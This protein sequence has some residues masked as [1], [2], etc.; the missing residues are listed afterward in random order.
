MAPG[1]ATRPDSAPL[2][3]IGRQ[4]ASLAVVIPAFRVTQQ[5]RGVIES[6]PSIVDLVYVVDDGCPDGSGRLVEAECTD[7]RVRVLFNA[8]NLGVGGA[9]LRGYREAI[10]D[11]AGIIVK[12]D[13]DG[14]MDPAMIERLVRPIQAGEADYSKGNRFYDLRGLGQMPR[15]RIFGNSVLS[16]MAKLSTGYWGIFDPANGFTAIHARVAAHLP[17]DRISKRYFFET[18][19]LFRLNTLRAVVADVPMPARYGDERSN[20]R[21]WRVA[22]E[23]AA[24][25]L[26]NFSKRVFYNYFLRDMSLASLELVAG[27]ALLAFGAVY[28][29]LRWFESASTGIAAPVGSIMLAVLPVLVGIQFLL[30]FLGFDIASAPRRPIH[31]DLPRS[32]GE[33]G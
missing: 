9:V 26:R 8:L 16:L 13:G 15:L 24:K 7:P 32:P 3:H 31:P 10:A 11:G 22:P 25:H 18:D 14:Q 21:E 1:S 23:F 6:L 17:A 30:A 27:I 29:G 5:V 2:R 12:V 19:L 4:A 33:P 20:L 28:G